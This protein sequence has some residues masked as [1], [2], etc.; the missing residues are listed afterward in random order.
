MNPAS[1]FH[2]DDEFSNRLLVIVRPNLGIQNVVYL[3]PI[4]HAPRRFVMTTTGEFAHAHFRTLGDGFGG[5]ACESDGGFG[6]HHGLSKQNDDVRC[7]LEGDVRRP[8]EGDDL[9]G[10]FENLSF[11][12]FERGSARDGADK[13]GDG[14]LDD[15]A[16]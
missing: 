9:Q 2:Q 14:G 4:I 10:L 13:T 12:Q 1:C 16:G 8:E 15:G 6:G 11:R 3:K 5:L 7:Q